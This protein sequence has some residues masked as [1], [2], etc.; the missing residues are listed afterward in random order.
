MKALH[1]SIKKMKITFL[2][3]GD[4]HPPYL[5]INFFLPHYTV[6]ELW[7]HGLLYFSFGIY[8]FILEKKEV[9]PIQK[10]FG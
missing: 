3:V 7:Y 8:H 6:C 2:Q 4:S 9:D 10:A 1:E 5:N